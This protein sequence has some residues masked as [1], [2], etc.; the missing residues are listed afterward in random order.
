MKFQEPGEVEIGNAIAVGEHERLALN[1]SFNALHPS[2]GHG[3]KAGIGQG[4]G[5][6]CSP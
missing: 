4:Y 2:A 5:E 6:A 3:V 1:V